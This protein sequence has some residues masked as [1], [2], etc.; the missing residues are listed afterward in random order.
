MEQ[1]SH[2]DTTEDLPMVEHHKLSGITYAAIALVVI[3]ALNWGLV[4]LFNF[5]LVAAI[6][7]RMSV[8]SRIIYVAIS[9]G[10]LYMIADAFRLREEPRRHVRATVT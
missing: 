10:G 8:L 3:G 9:L 1:P 7:G 2:D 5:D 4:G 6:F